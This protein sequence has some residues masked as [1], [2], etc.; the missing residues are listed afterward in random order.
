M[1]AQLNMEIGLISGDA[2]SAPRDQ[3]CR[4]AI[5]QKL[6]MDGF[7]VVRDYGKGSSA[8]LSLAAMSGDVQRHER[9]DADGVVLIE[10]V[11]GAPM[12]ESQFSG[13]GVQPFGWHTDG[14]YLDEVVQ[15]ADGLFLRIRPPKGLII[16]C[17]RPAEVGGELILCDSRAVLARMEHSD[18]R[19]H[20]ILS[21]SAVAAVCRG[22]RLCTRF[23]IIDGSTNPTRFRFRADRFLWV[24][25]DAADAVDVLVADYLSI[26]DF[27]IEIGLDAGDVVLIDNLR[28]LHSR[29]AIKRLGPKGRLMRRVW[30]ADE[31]DMLRAHNGSDAGQDYLTDPAI[32]A[33]RTNVSRVVYR[34]RIR[35]PNYSESVGQT[36]DRVWK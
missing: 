33:Y 3:I 4:E 28:M 34:D 29:L 16:Q 6:A 13:Q 30:I 18:P 35:W 12:N 7:A 5:S 26:P 2:E 20:A 14:T 19:L 25:P 10:A 8:L 17:V 32:D 11:D 23:P 21:R 24:A 27:H 22:G 1:N 31:P 36:Q 15:I 9:S